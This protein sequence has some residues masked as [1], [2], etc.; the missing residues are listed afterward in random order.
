MAITITS[1]Q[2]KA[3]AL[4]MA[5]KDIRYYLNGLMINENH[6]VA[7]DGHRMHIFYH[8][9]QWER[10]EIVIP[11]EIIDIVLKM[12]TVNIEITDKSVNSIPFNAL[13]GKFL[14][15]RRVMPSTALGVT[16]GAIVTNINA[17][18]LEDAVSAIRLVTG[19][20]RGAFT[21]SLV[22]NSWFWSSDAFAAVVMSYKADNATSLQRMQ[23]L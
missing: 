4:A 18:Y 11:R 16:E 1:A 21:L 20:K 7:T 6:I 17:D 8:G 19:K 10:G 2:L 22:G 12:K 5:K 3:V 14:D 23:G 9:Q 13:D 15:Y